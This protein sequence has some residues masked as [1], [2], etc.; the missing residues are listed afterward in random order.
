M[1][2]LLVLLSCDDIEKFA[3]L[4]S[5]KHFLVMSR[6][7][8]ECSTRRIFHLIRLQIVNFSTFGCTDV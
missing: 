5:I 2:P 1:K 4:L 3:P 7:G 8:V 6:T